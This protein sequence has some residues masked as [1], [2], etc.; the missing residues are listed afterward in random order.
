MSRLTNKKCKCD[1]GVTGATTSSGEARYHIHPGPRGLSSRGQAS[2]CMACNAEY[3]PPADKMQITCNDC[4]ESFPRP[5]MGISPQRC[6]PCGLNRRKA[7][8]MERWL[9]WAAKQG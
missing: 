9:R 6:E 5:R 7:Q 1:T 4:H 2:V 8:G 3:A